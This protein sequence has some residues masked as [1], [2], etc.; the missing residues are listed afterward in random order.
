[1]RHSR[2]R[3]LIMADDADSQRERASATAV[4]NLEMEGWL[5]KALERRELALHYQPQVELDSGRIVGVEALLRWQHS[6]LGK[7]SPAELI[8]LAERAGLISLL[9]EWMIRVA[10]TQ[11]QSWRNL[12]LPLLRV[13]VNLPSRQFVDAELAKVI[14]QILRETK[15]RPDFLELEITESLLVKEE[16]I[17]TL[18][19]LKRLGV[20]L[21][22]NDFGA[23]YANL[24]HWRQVSLD[25]LKIDRSFVREIG[26]ETDEQPIA[27][28]IIAMARSLRLGV[29]ADGVETAM[30]FAFLRSLRCDEIQGDWFGPPRPAEQFAALLGNYRK[31]RHFQ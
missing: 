7:A 30:Q 31:S 11:V 12:G 25:R 27:A 4:Q 14:A 22:I 10:C 8:P 16:V 23:D 5:R 3:P 1:M 21:A 18:R 15:L 17:D 19:A 26:E 2:E 28:A 13:A 20:R 9:G 6:I 29:I 24:R